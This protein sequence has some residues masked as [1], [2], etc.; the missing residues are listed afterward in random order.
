MVPVY[1]FLHGILSL[2]STVEYSNDVL[3]LVFKSRD[4]SEQS[5]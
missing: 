5:V 2:P 3:A 4:H 1:L